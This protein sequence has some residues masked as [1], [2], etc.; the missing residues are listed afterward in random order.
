MPPQGLSSEI[1]GD[2]RL[3]ASDRI[4]YLVANLA[5]NLAG[6]TA[7]LAMRAW[8]PPKTESDN[9]D[10]A[11]ASPSRW[12]T[13]AFIR[14]GLPGLL[15]RREV[16]ILDV[17]CGS[18]GICRPLVEAGFCG[19]YTGVDV[20]DQFAAGQWAKDAFETTFIQGDANSV[21]LE[22]PYD[23]ILS[24]SALEHIAD[25]KRLIERLDRLLAEDGIQVHFVPAP[26][27]LLVY[28]WHGYRQ[29]GAPA[30]AERFG[31][32]GTEVYRL[33][34]LASLLL[35]LIVIT[36][37]EIFFSLSPR[38]RWPRWYAFKLALCLRLDAWM[39]IL[40]VIHAV[41]VKRKRVSV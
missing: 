27:A 38:T 22:G 5:R 21:P 30:I 25:D 29:Y 24:V 14:H 41:C 16:A 4:R 13:E 19:R 40:P 37:P 8:W 1:N 35:H 17:G 3:P 2:L 20:I 18:G 10:T 7:S 28:L 39:P 34:G 33:G 26:A 12:L 36:G 31:T 9:A 23:L 6:G 15:N 32:E 11:T